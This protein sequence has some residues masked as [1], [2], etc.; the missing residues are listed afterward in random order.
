VENVDR[1]LEEQIK[2][3]CDQTSDWLDRR[4]LDDLA[5]KLKELEPFGPTTKWVGA[6]RTIMMSKRI[7]VAVAAAVVLAILLPAGYAAVEAVVKHFSVDDVVSFEYGEPNGM[8]SYAVSRVTLVTSNAAGDETEA[9]AQLEEFARLYLEGKAEEIRPGVWQV[10]LSSGE[11]F[12]YGGDPKHVTAQFTPEEK[13]Q[14]KRQFDEINE[15]RKAG[16]GERTFWKEIEKDG[17]HLW[18]YHVRYT[19]ASGAVVEL[20]ENGEAPPQ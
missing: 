3:L 16:Q 15:L 19:L 17:V 13:E 12:S 9:R 10:R 7:K 1:N 20:C 6:W 8:T 2:H 11:L 18:L 5:G 14:L 4:I